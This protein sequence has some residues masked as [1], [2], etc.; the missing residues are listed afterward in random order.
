MFVL[1]I[2]NEL[3]HLGQLL[4]FKGVVGHQADAFDA[5]VLEHEG[6]TPTS[7]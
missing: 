6:H 3:V 4:D 5:H 2:S 1:K 7:I